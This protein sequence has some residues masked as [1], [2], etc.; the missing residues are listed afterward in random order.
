M[1]NHDGE[2]LTAA[3]AAVRLL[4]GRSFRQVFSAPAA[5]TR[6]G[7]DPFPTWREQVDACRRRPD[8]LT[9]PLTVGQLDTLAPIAAKVATAKAP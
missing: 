6:R 1:L 8:L 4:A 2:A 9:K 7:R 3:R 5:T